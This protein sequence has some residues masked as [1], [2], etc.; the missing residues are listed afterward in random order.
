MQRLDLYVTVLFAAGGRIDVPLRE[1]Q[2]AVYKNP[3]CVFAVILLESYEDGKSVLS[4]LV[5]NSLDVVGACRR[6]PP[7]QDCFVVYV[8]VWHTPMHYCVLN[9]HV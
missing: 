8:S 3:L 1:A 2:A 6:E 5:F 7:P 4:L 9:Q